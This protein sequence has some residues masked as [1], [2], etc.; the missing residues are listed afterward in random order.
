MCWQGMQKL[1]S[2]LHDSYTAVGIQ[3]ASLNYVFS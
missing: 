3:K 1:K 2:F